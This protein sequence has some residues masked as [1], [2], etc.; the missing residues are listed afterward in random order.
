MTGRSALLSQPRLGDLVGAVE[1]AP[2]GSAG[3]RG[4]H[5][6]RGPRKLDSLRANLIKEAQ[7]IQERLAAVQEE[8]AKRK[9]DATAG[10]G[11]VTVEANGE[12]E[13]VSIKIDREVVN[14]DDLQ[15]LEDLVLA[16]RGG[17]GRRTRLLE[18]HHLR[19]PELAHH[20]GLHDGTSGFWSGRRL[21]FGLSRRHGP[22]SL[23]SSYGALKRWPGIRP[24]AGSAT[25]GP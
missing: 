17:C 23:T 13:L 5:P 25:R 18:P 21:R 4:H 6:L 9:V 16:V 10:G 24:S 1:E 12:Q 3:T 20:H 15:M 2:P 7:K 8:V 19:P 22:L 11:M 14:P